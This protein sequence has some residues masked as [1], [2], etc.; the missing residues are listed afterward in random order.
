MHIH[1]CIYIYIYIYIYTYKCV[2]VCVHLVARA[3]WVEGR[4]SP[5]REQERRCVSF[6]LRKGTCFALLA[7]ACLRF[8]SVRISGRISG[9]CFCPCISQSRASNPRSS[10]PQQVTYPYSGGTVLQLKNPAAREG[11]RYRGWGCTRAVNIQFSQDDKQGWGCG[12]ARATLCSRSPVGD[13]GLRVWVV[14][15][16][17]D[18]GEIQPWQNSGVTLI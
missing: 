11:V 16:R 5:E 6:E 1:V 2:C 7:I 10:P 18:D 14:R 15:V 8:L 3:Y 4:P 12:R 13:W 9:A 17:E